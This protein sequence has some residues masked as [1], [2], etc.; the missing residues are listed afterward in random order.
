M[1][2]SV[3]VFFDQFNVSNNMLILDDSTIPSS[4]LKGRLILHLLYLGNI[5]YLYIVAG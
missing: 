3:N 1:V 5:M 4:Y 2:S